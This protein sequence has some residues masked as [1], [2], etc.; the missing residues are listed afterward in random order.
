MYKVLIPEDV[1]E[2]GKNYL[3]ERGYELKIGVPTDVE[4]LKREVAD[5][6]A[7]L[8]RNARYPREVIQAGQKLK[9]IAR[10][11]TGVDNIAVADAEAMGIWVVNGPTANINAVAE[12]AVAL[13]MALSC[14]LVRSN[15]RTRAGDWSFRTHMVRRELNGQTLGLVGFGRIGRLVAQKAIDGLGMKVI[16]YDPMVSAD[17]PQGAAV[18]KDLLQMLEASDYVSVHI[19][20][21]PQTKG[22]FDYKLF[23]HMKP[24]AAFINC[25]R[26][27]ICV[28]ADLIRALNEGVI[29]GAALDVYE[30]EPLLNSPLCSMDQVI[31]SQHSAGLSKESKERMSLYAAIGIDEVLN[32]KKPSWPVNNPLRK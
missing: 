27:D 20:S 23:S 25:A 4:S 21:T 3:L 8:V 12:Y 32:G 15:E 31:L 28:E 5:A 22:L 1:A 2:S 17:I 9:V 26:G 16:A 18:T 11:G 30:H 24:S 10:H 13:V 19:P 29:T 7:L 6:D 14:L